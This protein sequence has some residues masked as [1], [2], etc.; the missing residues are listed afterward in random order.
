[1]AGEWEIA[2]NSRG[3][4]VSPQLSSKAGRH[5]LVWFYKIVLNKVFVAWDEVHHGK[6]RISMNINGQLCAWS[7]SEPSGFIIRDC[8][9]LQSCII[10]F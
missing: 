2:V 8:I 10:L 1:M 6:I 5:T 9:Q 3:G 7:R 4:E